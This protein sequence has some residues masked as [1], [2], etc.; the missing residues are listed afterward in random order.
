MV[1]FYTCTLTCSVIMWNRNHKTCVNITLKFNFF[2]KF[3]VDESF[4]FYVLN[5]HIPKNLFLPIVV[6]R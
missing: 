6:K 2:P 5:Y 3:M 4:S 1:A